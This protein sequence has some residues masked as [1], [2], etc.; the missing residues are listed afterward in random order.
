MAIRA[1]DGANKLFPNEFVSVTVM[2]FRCAFVM[3]VRCRNA[4]SKPKLSFA[5]LSKAILLSFLS[6]L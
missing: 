2:R 4:L 6:A 3:R 1:P 5:F